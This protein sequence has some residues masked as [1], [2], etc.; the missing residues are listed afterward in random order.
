MVGYLRGY[1]PPW[2]PTAA[3]KSCVCSEGTAL[4]TILFIGTVKMKTLP[5]ELTKTR[6]RSMLPCFWSR[7]PLR[8]DRR[9]SSSH[10]NCPC[11]TNSLTSG[12]S[13]RSSSSRR[14]H[15]KLNLRKNM[16][17][18]LCFRACH[19]HRGLHSNSQANTSSNLS[20]L[21]TR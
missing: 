7:W 21:S 1:S 3:M 2:V 9:M 17:E 12:D 5:N 15:S 19:H 10:H 11:L 4:A 6:R 16:R 20:N 18:W 8:K 13:C 14:P